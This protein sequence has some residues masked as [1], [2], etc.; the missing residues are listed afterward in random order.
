MKLSEGYLFGYNQA[1]LQVENQVAKQLSSRGKLA[2]S[3]AE[4]RVWIQYRPLIERINQMR[5]EQA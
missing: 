3:D 2:G 5:K 4:N 1:L